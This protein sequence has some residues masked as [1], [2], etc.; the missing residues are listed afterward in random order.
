MER[1]RNVS[2]SESGMC[3]S[4]YQ[5]FVV[6]RLEIIIRREE[7]E[8]RGKLE[9]DCDGRNSIPVLITRLSMQPE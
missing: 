9:A 7:G 4:V 8:E 6:R 2:Q 5:K 1:E 3:V